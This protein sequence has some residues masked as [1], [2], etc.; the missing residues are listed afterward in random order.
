MYHCCFSISDLLITDL[1]LGHRKANKKVSAGCCSADS[2]HVFFADRFG[3]VL[4]GKVNT[5]AVAT[6]SAGEGSSTAAA[7]AEESNLLLGHLQAIVTSLTPTPTCNLLISTDRD[8]KVRASIMPEDPLKVR[9]GM[10]FWVGHLH[11]TCDRAV[12]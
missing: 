11:K 6:A 12:V 8:C 3:D 4:V 5:E 9:W 7:V 10:F 2:K 1:S